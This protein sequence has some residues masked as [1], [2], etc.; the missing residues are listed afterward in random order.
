MKKFT[1]TES[2]NLREF[3]DSVY[4]QGSF[5]LPALLR[6]GDVKINGVRVK[7]NARVKCGDEVTYYTTPSQEAK[8]SHTVAYEDESVLI[9]DK[10]SGVSS[11][12]LFNELKEFNALYAV[13]RLDRNTLGLIVYAKTAEAAQELISAFAQR[14]VEKTYYCIA[15]NNFKD[16]YAYLTAYL[17]KDAV[18]GTVKIYDA[19]RSGAVKI[20]TEYSV[21]TVQGDCALVRI[22]LH[23]GKTHQIRAHLAHIGCPVLGDNK[24]GDDAFNS[25][26]GAR[27]QRLVAQK[28]KF[29][30]DG[31]LSYLNGKDFQ[32][33]HKLELPQK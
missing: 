6:A 28:L 32:S 11:E 22:A 3:T 24:Y 29:R 10:E 19:P 2:G 7:N 13:H 5:C 23:T 1:V 4:P 18:S 8:K 25:K 12:A 30:L 17:K 15:K 20:E 16:E 31:A 27:R 9:A 21:E 26:Y 14:K 33:S